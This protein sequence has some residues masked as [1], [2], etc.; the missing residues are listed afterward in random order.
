MTRKVDSSANVSFAGTSYRAGNKFRRRQ[1]QVAVVAGTFEISVGN[2][3]IRVHPVKHDRTREH[4]RSPTPAVGPTGSTLPPEPLIECQVGTGPHLSG[5]Y[6]TLT[7]LTGLTSSGIS[8]HSRYET[9]SYSRLGV[10]SSH[11][12]PGSLGHLHVPD[13]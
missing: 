2:E 12:S 1:V 7:A 13:A 3:L 6:R 10:G 5:G 8:S 11:L 9:S 4:V